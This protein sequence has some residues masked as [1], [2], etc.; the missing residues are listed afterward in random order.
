MLAVGDGHEIHGETCGNPDGVPVVVLHGGPGS[1][2][3]AGMRRFFDPI[4]FR[5]VLFGAWRL[6]RAWP[7][8]RLVVVD[9]A[10]HSTADA[11]MPAAIVAA[12]TALLAVAGR[13]SSGG[14]LLPGV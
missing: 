6:A 1:G 8:A 2:C 4:G 7:D 12:T 14:E 10:G 3:S 11:G 9:A 5:I 13:R